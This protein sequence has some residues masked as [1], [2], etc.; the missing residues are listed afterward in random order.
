MSVDGV[1]PA[2]LAWPDDFVWR[3]PVP[4]P[5]AWG[6]PGLVMLFNLECPGCI[7]RGVP[8]LK[9]LGS[10]Y[11]ERLQLVMVHTAFGRRAY[12][13]DE[14]VPTLTHFAESFA[15]LEIPVALDVDGSLAEDWG[16]EGTPHWLAFDREGE[17]ARSI[18]GSQDNA[19]TRL[20]YLVEELLADDGGV[21]G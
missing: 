18:Y 4:A 5:Q 7:S 9:R 15:R 11:G 21:P 3:G 1:P 10:E 20:A 17:L 12:P 2:G 14:V 13:R 6:K 19:Q 16:A 8:F